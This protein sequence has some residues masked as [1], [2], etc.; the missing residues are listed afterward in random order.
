MRRADRVSSD[1]FCQEE[2]HVS[3]NGI[4]HENAGEHDDPDPARARAG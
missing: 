3:Q 4:A 2:N 1:S